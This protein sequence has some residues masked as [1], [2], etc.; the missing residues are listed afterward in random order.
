VVER[1]PI[2]EKSGWP[3]QLVELPHALLRGA[4]F[5]CS[6]VKVLRP[7]QEAAVEARDAASRSRGLVAN[8]R[9]PTQHRL[10]RRSAGHALSPSPQLL[11]LGTGGVLFAFV[12]LF[13]R[14]ANSKLAGT[15]LGGRHAQQG[16]HKA[17]H[18][19]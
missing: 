2:A 10:T 5:G 3:L 8:E 16:A 11:T 1:L 7:K 9:H 18:Y 19:G 14:W 6:A 13:L 17:R 12:Q 4:F 15:T